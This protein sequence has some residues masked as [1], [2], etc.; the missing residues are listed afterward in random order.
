MG[1]HQRHGRSLPFDAI[2]TNHRRLM[3]RQQQHRTAFQQQQRRRGGGGSGRRFSPWE[4]RTLALSRERE[5]KKRSNKNLQRSFYCD[6]EIRT[7][8]RHWWIGGKGLLVFKSLKLCSIDCGRRENK[9]SP[10][11]LDQ[12]ST[13]WGYGIWREEGL[14]LGGV[15]I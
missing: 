13:S 7:K 5:K 15:W 9:K 12:R 1:G 14:W 6:G 4:S 2:F 3:A 8:C 10:K 11:L